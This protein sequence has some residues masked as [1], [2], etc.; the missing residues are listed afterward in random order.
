MSKVL[1][2]TGDGGESY[3][4]LYAVH[5][6][7][8]EG[9]QAVVAAPSQRRLH[10]VMHDFEPGWDTYIERSGYGLEAHI[11]FGDVKV[12]E[13]AAVLVLGGR[14]PEYLRNNALVLEIVREFDGQGKWVFA[15]CHGVQVLG[16]AGLIRGKRVTCY[17]HVRLEA[18]QAGAT[19]VGEQSVRDGRI[20]TAQTWQ[21]HPSFYREIFAQLA[22]NPGPSVE[23][24]PVQV[25][26]T[27]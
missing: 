20:I 6:F 23:L 15:I 3:E 22:G 12:D 21:S 7:E 26:N 2:I 14:A 13:Y 17:E 25:G 16:A 4:A 27:A 1:I 5:R 8:E 24:K 10:L 18:E 11:A 19:F 9:W